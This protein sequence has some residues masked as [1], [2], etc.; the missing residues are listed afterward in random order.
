MLT[1]PHGPTVPRRR[2]RRAVAA[3]LPVVAGRA[4]QPGRGAEDDRGGREGEQERS[5][6][7]IGSGEKFNNLTKFVASSELDNPWG[8]FPRRDRRSLRLMSWT[9][10]RSRPGG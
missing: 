6:P 9:D 3:G 10:R 2:L 1:L 8:D 5:E 4:E 7:R